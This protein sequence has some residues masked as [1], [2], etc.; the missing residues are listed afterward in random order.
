MLRMIAEIIGATFIVW[1]ALYGAE[2]WLTRWKDG[3]NQPPKED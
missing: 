3:P 2:Q 1:I